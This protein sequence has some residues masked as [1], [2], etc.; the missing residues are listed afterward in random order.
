[1]NKSAII[2]LSGGLDSFVSLAAAL[3][4]YDVKLALTFDYSQR[5]FMEEFE[6]SSEIC[7]YYKIEHKVIKLPFL[8]QI[9]NTALAD[10]NKNLEFDTLGEES[11][12]AVWVPN[13]NGLFLNIAASYADSMNIDYIIIGANKEEAGTFSD[14]SLEFLKLADEFFNY[15][16]QKH[17]KIL[18][19]LA[20]LEK[21]QI[22]NLAL[23]KKAP[24]KL[25]KSCYDSK[26]KT[27]A[28][29]CGK[30]ESCKR[31]KAA[32]LK[33]VNKDLLNLFF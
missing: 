17:P 28:K 5:A 20:N 9:T 32:I 12:N 29:H 18:A 19:P 1:M 23:E 21:Y 13:R 25:I 8:A 30:C 26:E 14:N 11:K 33:S 6:A 10:E 3:E 31:L 2:L 27:G 4:E 24:L 15:S 16:T 22:I 7:K